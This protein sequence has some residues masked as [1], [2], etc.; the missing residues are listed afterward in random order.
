MTWGCGQQ[1]VRGGRDSVGLLQ[2]GCP[3]AGR[4]STLAQVAEVIASASPIRHLDGLPNERIT[5][6]LATVPVGSSEIDIPSPS[7]QPW[8]RVSWNRGSTSPA[9]RWAFPGFVFWFCSTKFALHS[10]QFFF[11]LFPFLFFSFSNSSFNNCASVGGDFWS[12]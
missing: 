7:S 12:H 3:C 10:S 1:E 11:S 4:L 8:F 9:E 2:T 5:S 6:T